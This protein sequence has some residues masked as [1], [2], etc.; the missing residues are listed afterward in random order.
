[1]F[2]IMRSSFSELMRVHYYLSYSKLIKLTGSRYYAMA[3]REKLT[4]C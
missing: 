3:T 2:K 4:G 1:M